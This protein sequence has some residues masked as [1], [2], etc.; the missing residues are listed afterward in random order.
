ML[1]DSVRIH[2]VAIS[3]SVKHVVSVLKKA[4]WSKKD[5]EHFLMHQ[6]ARS[7]ISGLAKQYNE[8]VQ[9]EMLTKD[10]MIYNLEERGNTSSTTHYVAVWDNIHKEDYLYLNHSIWYHHLQVFH[11]LNLRVL[12]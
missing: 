1:T 4:K 12:F 8:F 6:T 9:Q 5:L 10:N 11:K 3:E 2:A 7:A